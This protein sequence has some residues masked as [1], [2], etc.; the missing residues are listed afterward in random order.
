MTIEKETNFQVYPNL[1]Q[2]WEVFGIF[3][4][5][6]FGLEFIK[7]VLDHVF[8]IASFPPETGEWLGFLIYF[9]SMFFTALY[10]K[11]AS[12]STDFDYGFAIAKSPVQLFLILA[13]ISPALIIINGSIADIIPMPKFIEESF[14]SMIRPNF[15][16]FLTVVIAA[17][18]ME[19]LLCKGIILRG[20][21]HNMSANKA[22]L[23]S[24][25][26]F[27]ILHMNPWQGIPAF[28]IGL[29]SGWIFWKT[30]SVIPCIFL[31]LMNNGV[32][33][34]FLLLL[35]NPLMSMSDIFNVYY[36]HVLVLSAAILSACLY[37]IY[38]I[39][40]K[41]ESCNI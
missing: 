5:I 7:Y 11:N 29:I 10:V 41:P 37:V 25:L 23:W 39:C 27:A 15:P 21:I 16:S 33:F 19:E 18:V 12:Q 22:I 20:L 28:I 4:I 2:M 13:V 6:N 24:A 34:I 32:G 40:K 36:P 3:I 1:K 30:K 26:F 35:N 8:K 17:P 31:H 14:I 38:K 9:M